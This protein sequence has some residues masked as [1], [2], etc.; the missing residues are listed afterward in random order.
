MIFGLIVAL[1]PGNYYVVPRNGRNVD[2]STGCWLRS[3]L[4]GARCLNS[5]RCNRREGT[6]LNMTGKLGGAPLEVLVDSA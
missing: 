2:S 6:S 3:A 1:I 5:R 4:P